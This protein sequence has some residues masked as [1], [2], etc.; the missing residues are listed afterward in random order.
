MRLPDKNTKSK[1]SKSRGFTLLEIVITLAIIMLLAGSITMI[2]SSTLGLTQ[3]LLERQDE[4]IQQQEVEEFLETLFTDLGSEAILKMEYTSENMQTLTVYN[5][6]CYFPFEGTAQ[7]A[8]IIILETTVNRLG[9]RDLH[10]LCYKQRNNV[11]DSLPE[12]ADY[13]ITL[14]KDIYQ[15]EWSCFYHVSNEWLQQWEENIGLPKLMKLEYK[16]S[17]QEHLQRDVFKIFK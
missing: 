7:F 15:I 2:F 6:N 5:S 11:T 9:S 3:A 1:N 12:K 17:N 13:Q 14:M 4:D 8:A 10:L 16:T